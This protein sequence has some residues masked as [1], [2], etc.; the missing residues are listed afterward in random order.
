MGEG[1]IGIT[2]KDMKVGAKVKFKELSQPQL[3]LLIT[4]LEY[5]RKKLQEE[6]DKG[7][8]FTEGK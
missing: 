3:A 5:I 2:L 1:V 4:H 6:Y 8:V 7:V